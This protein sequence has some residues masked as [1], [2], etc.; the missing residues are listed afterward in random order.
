MDTGVCTTCNVPSDNLSPDT[1]QCEDC[2]AEEKKVSDT[3]MED[4]NA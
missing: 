3:G 2:T 4:E 1:E